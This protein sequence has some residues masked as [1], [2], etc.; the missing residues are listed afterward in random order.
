[1]SA[2]KVAR[3]TS[4]AKTF[5]KALEAEFAKRTQRVAERVRAKLRENLSVAGSGTPSKPGEYSRSQSGEMAR[6]VKTVIAKRS[7]YT[8]RIVNRAPHDGA[9]EFGTKAGQV[10]TPKK[11]S[12][13]VFTGGTVGSK[14]TVFTKRVRRGAIK[15][16]GNAR[17]TL[18]SMRAVIKAIYTR[19]IPDMK[20]GKNRTIVRIG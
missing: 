17:R 5:T 11:A 3:V 14:R 2:P 12:A 20:S 8:V 7:P 10:I 1:M 19:G 9:Q 13:L 6:G 4:Y 15:A 16:R 18:E